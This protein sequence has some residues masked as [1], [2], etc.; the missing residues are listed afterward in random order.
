M[1][2]NPVIFSTCGQ[3]EAL[4]FEWRVGF[5]MNKGKGGAGTPRAIVG[6]TSEYS[7]HLLLK[8]GTRFK[9]CA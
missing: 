9:R 5:N 3:N 7:K 4:V 6:G 8:V 2:V 1:T